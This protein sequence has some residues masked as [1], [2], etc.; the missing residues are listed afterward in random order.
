MPEI[1]CSYLV[2]NGAYCCCYVN[3]FSYFLLINVGIND[4]KPKANRVIK[5]LGLTPILSISF[6]VSPV[7]IKMKLLGIKPEI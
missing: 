5:A 2:L 1:H 4:K 6:K 3:F 7:W